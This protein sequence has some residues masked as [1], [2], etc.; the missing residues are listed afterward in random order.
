MSREVVAIISCLAAATLNAAWAGA[1]HGADP[2]PESTT[3]LQ[4]VAPEATSPEGAALYANRCAACHD[5]ASGRVPPKVLISV[6]RA[7]EDVMRQ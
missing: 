6:T 3:S 4:V 5:H 2:Q 1:R 7:A